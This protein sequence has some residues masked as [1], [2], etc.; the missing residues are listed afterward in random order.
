MKNIVYE[1]LFLRPT[2]ISRNGAK[3]QR[4]FFHFSKE[5]PITGARA[6]R[7]RRGWGGHQKQKHVCNQNIHIFGS[8]PVSKK[9]SRS[10]AKAQRGFFHFSKEFPITGGK[11]PSFGGVG[12][13]TK[14]KNIYVIKTSTSSEVHPFQKK[15][16][17][18]AQRRNV[19]S[20]TSVKNFQ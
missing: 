20:S 13:S 19:A 7:L 15:Y 4:G 16:P 2:S 17:A 8:A 9:I 6:P 18:A 1:F 10:G 12:E 3:A 11:S 5:F 14:N